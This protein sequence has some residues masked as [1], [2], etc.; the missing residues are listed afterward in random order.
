[1]VLYNSSKGYLAFSLIPINIALQ[2]L[3]LANLSKHLSSSSLGTFLLD[4]S[5]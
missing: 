1:M 2:F 5:I 3:D 4:K